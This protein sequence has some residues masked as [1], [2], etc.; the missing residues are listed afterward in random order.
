MTGR[1]RPLG[2]LVAAVGSLGWFDPSA[3]PRAAA[4]FYGDGKFDDAAARYNEALIDEPD[5]RLLHFNLGDAEYRRGRFDAAIRAFQQ[6]PQDAAAEYNRGNALFRKGEAAQQEK[7]QDALTHWAEA[8]V[9]YRRAIGT[10]PTDEDAKFNYEWVSRKIDE[11]K[12][13]L[14]E[15]RQDQQKQQQQDQQGQQDQ[16]QPQDQPKDE[17]EERAEEREQ[18]EPPSERAEQAD[19]P[20]DG[21]MSRDEATALLDAERS[22]ELQPDEVIRRQLGTG[23]VPA[24]DW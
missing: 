8:L 21:R 4:R 12:K 13:Q 19:A 7:P 11:L 5:S 15:Q 22:E 23:D 20:A 10:D 1:W 3:A 2:L 18:P 17:P 16:Q 24:Q 14:E 9:A 6:V